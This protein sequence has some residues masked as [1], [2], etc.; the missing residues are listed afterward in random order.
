MRTN[1]GGQWRCVLPYRPKSPRPGSWPFGNTQPRFS[2]SNPLAKHKRLISRRWSEFARNGRA[3]PAPG[4]QFAADNGVPFFGVRK[5]ASALCC[6][7]IQAKFASRFA[8][9][10]LATRGACAAPPKRASARKSGSKLPHSKGRRSMLAQRTWLLSRAF[11]AP[12]AR[13]RRPKRVFAGRPCP[14]RF[15]PS[16]RYPGCD[17]IRR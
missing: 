8:A 1:P 5:L 4:M 2:T 9:S 6:G 15:L 3:K 16:K 14:S 13:G 11:R 12:F 7:A 10:L 17:R